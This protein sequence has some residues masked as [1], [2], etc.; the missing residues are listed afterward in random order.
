VDY[1]SRDDNEDFQTTLA[2]DASVGLRKITHEGM[3]HRMTYI[4]GE[5][6]FVTNEW[7]MYR[8]PSGYVPIKGGTKLVRMSLEPRERRM[9]KGT[10]LEYARLLPLVDD[11]GAVKNA[12]LVA[13]ITG[14]LS[15][16]RSTVSPEELV[17]GIAKTLSYGH[18]RAGRGWVPAQS[19]WAR[20]NTDVVTMLSGGSASVVV[21]TPEVALVRLVGTKHKAVVLNNGRVVGRAVLD[22]QGAVQVYVRARD[23]PDR[24]V[25]VAARKGATAMLRRIFANKVTWEE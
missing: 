20:V 15:E 1:I 13:R 5:D 25:R 16:F 18:M 17:F 14:Q 12:A 7:V 9:S 3:S 4:T 10:Y 21:P 19:A 24:S 8:V 11:V 2:Y 6:L 23:W 22:G